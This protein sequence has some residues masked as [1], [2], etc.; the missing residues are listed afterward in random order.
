MALAADGA[1]LLDASE[2]EHLQGLID[3][4]SGLLLANDLDALRN[5]TDQL[6]RASEAFAGRR[7]D[8]SIKKALSGV[9]LETLD[10]EVGK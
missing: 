4:L 6:G 1:A 8:Q 5:A 3:G 7:M 10:D 2:R 9:A